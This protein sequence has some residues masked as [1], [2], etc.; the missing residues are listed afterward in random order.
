MD[1]VVV[2]ERLPHDTSG[3]VLTWIELVPVDVE[4]GTDKEGD[5]NQDEYFVKRQSAQRLN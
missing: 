2:E 4:L 1:G 3:V 5:H